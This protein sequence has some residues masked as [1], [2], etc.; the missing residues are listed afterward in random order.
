MFVVS[1]A[2]T[3]SSHPKLKIPKVIV[4]RSYAHPLK[5]LTSFIYLTRDELSFADGKLI[6]QLR[7]AA[8]EVD[9]GKCKNA[10]V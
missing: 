9:S 3:V 4:E 2:L 8:C 1:Y 7:D 6:C 10:I 5:E